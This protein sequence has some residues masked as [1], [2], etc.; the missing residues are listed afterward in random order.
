MA[1]GYVEKYQRVL[2]GERLNAS[3]PTLKENGHQLMPWNP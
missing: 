2:D 1:R 3:R